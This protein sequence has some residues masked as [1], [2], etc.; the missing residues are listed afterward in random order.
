MKKSSKSSFS[1]YREIIYITTAFF[2]V[3]NL[4]VLGLN[5][6]VASSI[7]A[8]A[9]AIDIAGRQRMLSQRIDKAVYAIEISQRNGTPVEP[10]LK[11]LN[12][13]AQLFDE[14]LTAFANGGE[15]MGNDGKMVTLR[16]ID[17]PKALVI[18]ADLQRIWQK[19]KG[20]IAQLQ[21]DYRNPEFLNPIVNAALAENKGILALMTELTN[22]KQSIAQ[23]RARDLRLIQS[24]SIVAATLS[25]PFVLLF[26]I[27][28]LRRSDAETEIAQ[29][30]TED[31]L[32]TAREGLFLLNADFRIGKQF[33]SSLSPLLDW[34]VA[35]GADFKDYLRRS[36]S[37]K[38]FSDACDFIELL[39][40]DRVLEDLIGDINP[41]ENIPVGTHEGGEKRY[42]SFRFNQVKNVDSDARLLLV[43]VQDVTEQTLLAMTL[44]E[45][46]KEAKSEISVLLNLLDADPILLKNFL[47]HAKESLEYVNQIF[48]KLDKGA[49][50]ASLVNSIFRHV[51]TLKGEAA[52]LNL[53]VFVQSFQDF[54]GALRKLRE[55]GIALDGESLLS[56]MPHLEICFAKVQQVGQVVARLQKFHSGASPASNEIALIAPDSILVEDPLAEINAF[57]VQTE[58][59]AQRI[60][61]SEGKQVGLKANLQAM[62]DCDSSQRRHIYSII[63]QCVRNAVVHGIETPATRRTVGKATQ[64]LIEVDLQIDRDGNATLKCS[65]DGYGL[66]ADHIRQ[67][68]IS[69]G[70]YTAAELKDYT[71]QQIVGE[72]FKSGVSTATS[73]GQDAGQGVGLSVVKEGAQ[74]LGGKLFLN[75]KPQK[76]T[77]FSVQFKV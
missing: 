71:P 29:R 49:Q 39:F 59:L 17:S 19:R 45:V 64:G 24:G 61:N 38:N 21:T 30:E 2:L 22:V 76:S 46:R 34:A 6:Y 7:S 11:E 4:L 53:E 56:L 31:I 28:R 60:A 1:R 35:P 40:N 12:S 70:R 69:S 54:E 18:M 50:H 66:D 77:T 47:E 42:L 9:T 13:A 41:L 36:L 62:A 20:Q 44:E 48:E 57:A 10:H 52:T 27:R 25:F 14:T 33:S 51:H 68:L 15:V 26:L 37:A 3:F 16:R 43:T 75:S 5:Y 67:S 72:I 65:D 73:V 55:S 8:D 74:K 32:S 58:N 63:T 23:A